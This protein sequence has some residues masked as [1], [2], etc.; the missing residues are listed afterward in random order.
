MS[1]PF[2]FRSPV[3]TKGRTF[4]H[5]CPMSRVL[6]ETWGIFPLTKLTGPRHRRSLTSHVREPPH[7]WLPRL[8]RPPEVVL[9]LHIHP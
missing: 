8:L 2:C 9:G 7:S 5:G 1:H 3:P 6:C 4:T